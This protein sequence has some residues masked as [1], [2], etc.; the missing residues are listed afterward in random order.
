MDGELGNHLSSPIRWRQSVECTGLACRLVSP[1]FA[2]TDPMDRSVHWSGPTR[3]AP[4][5]L[6]LPKGEIADSFE[7][8]LSDGKDNSCISTVASPRAKSGRFSHEM[9]SEQPNNGNAPICVFFG[10]QIAGNTGN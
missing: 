10:E 6:N 5:D 1:L 4:A 9:G 7:P 8:H 3:L 2:P